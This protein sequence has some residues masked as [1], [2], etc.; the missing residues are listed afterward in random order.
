MGGLV[1]F[2][3]V[4]GE[5][6]VPGRYLMALGADRLCKDEL[7]RLVL[8]ADE[9]IKLEKALDSIEAHTRYE[10]PECIQNLNLRNPRETIALKIMYRQNPEVLDLMIFQ[11]PDRIAAV[12]AEGTIYAV[13]S[14]LTPQDMKELRDQLQPPRGIPEIPGSTCR[15]LRT[16]IENK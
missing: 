3:V 6:L 10:T 14:M 9:I 1:S 11:H 7:A 12:Q 15:R 8:Y 16:A 5:I 2:G 13:D 4:M